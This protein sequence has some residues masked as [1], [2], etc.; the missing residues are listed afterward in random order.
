MAAHTIKPRVAAMLARVTR[1][2]F[3]VR[4]RSSFIYGTGEI[5]LIPDGEGRVLGRKWPKEAKGLKARLSQ[6]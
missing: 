6:T 2:E 5:R 1:C 4:L 3:I